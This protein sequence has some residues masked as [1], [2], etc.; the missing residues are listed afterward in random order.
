MVKV[1]FVVPLPQALVKFVILNSIAPSVTGRL[2]VSHALTSGLSN[3]LA[4]V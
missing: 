1:K 2:Y 4:T 3:T